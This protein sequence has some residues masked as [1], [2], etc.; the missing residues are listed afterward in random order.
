[1]RR[2]AAANAEADAAASAQLVRFSTNELYELIGLL[3]RLERNP[4][5]P[6]SREEQE[7]LIFLTSIYR[8]VL[9]GGAQ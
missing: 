7:R 3:N 4:D 8:H 1:M 9:N 2:D 5:I 6:L